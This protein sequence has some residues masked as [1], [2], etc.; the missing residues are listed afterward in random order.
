MKMSFERDSH[1]S[2]NQGGGNIRGGGN[3]W[4]EGAKLTE[5]INEK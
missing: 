3:K 5:F 1:V 2:N 4:G